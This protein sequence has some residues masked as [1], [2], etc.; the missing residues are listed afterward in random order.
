MNEI[1]SISGPHKLSSQLKV[2]L[3]S[4]QK[5]ASVESASET[6]EF[7]Q[8]ELKMEQINHAFTLVNEIRSSLESALRNLS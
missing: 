3:E 7:K 6:Q 5:Q 2:S 4:T 1:S 8:L